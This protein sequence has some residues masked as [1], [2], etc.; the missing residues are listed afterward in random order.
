[1]EEKRDMSVFDG[2]VALACVFLSAVLFG[3]VIGWVA[4]GQ[5]DYD[6]ETAEWHL[7]R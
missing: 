6:R 2:I 3:A 7:K 4:R 1:M 5:F